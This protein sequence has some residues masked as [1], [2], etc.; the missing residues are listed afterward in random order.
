MEKDMSAALITDIGQ[1]Y[2]NTA[3]VYSHQTSLHFH[4]LHLPLEHNTSKT[5]CLPDGHFEDRGYTQESITF[6]RLLLNFP[7]SFRSLDLTYDL[8]P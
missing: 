4:I 5:A 8:P 7:H 2:S 1:L 6:S 3:G